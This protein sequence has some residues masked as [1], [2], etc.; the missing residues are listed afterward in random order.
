MFIDDSLL[1]SFYGDDFSG[2][3]DVMEAL[4]LAGVPTTLFLA[5][6]DGEVL[7]R[8]P[9]SQAIGI[10][11][12]SRSLEGDEFDT[13]LRT[14]FES[15][16]ELGAP[17]VHY[18]ICST[19]DSSPRTGSIGRAIELGLERFDSQLVPVVPAA[20]VLG[21]YCAFG[22]LFARS[23]LDSPIHRLDRH[24]TMSQH[25][26]TPM[27]ESDLRKVLGQQTS[28]AVGLID[29]SH[30]EGGVLTAKHEVRRLL[31]K[32][33][34]VALVD[35]VVDDHL[36]VIGGLL[37]DIRRVAAVTPS[38]AAFVVGSSGIEYALCEYLS[39][40]G[41]IAPPTPKPVL[42]QRSQ[43]ACVSG[44]CSPVTAAQIEYALENGFAEVALSPQ[45]LLLSH[46]SLEVERVVEEA[47]R[48]IRS[49]LS[50]IVHSSRG[51][52]DPR[53]LE[54]KEQLGNELPG[55]GSAEIIGEALGQVLRKIHAAT[56]L[57]RLCVT[58]GDTSG[59]VARC[60]GIEALQF[61]APVAPGS[62]VCRIRSLP[63]DRACEGVEIAFKGGQVGHQDYLVRVRDGNRA[64]TS[65][66]PRSPKLPAVR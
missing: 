56:G 15:L 25:P 31:K 11:G 39:E 21:R 22:N 61:V 60:L 58:G 41:H 2:S 66:A 49:G 8:Y 5:P 46:P 35:T 4:S 3:A 32:R 20:P 43:I 50:V 23:G 34:R 18:K 57:N 40:A 62:P 14:A 63:E 26:T 36:A 16:A 6:P 27:T 28:L 52:E 13:E 59:Y 65:E 19:F 47:V 17:L 38:N 54:T 55:C 51:P 1:L 7:L 24:P 12:L 53:V 42:S 30:L 10:A 64:A 29:V 33:Y 45:T 37:W 9:G 44:S 48:A